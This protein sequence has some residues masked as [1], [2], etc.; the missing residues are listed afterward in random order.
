LIEEKET[1]MSTADKIAEQLTQAQ[2]TIKETQA[3]VEKL[4]KE[5]EESKKPKKWEPKGGSWYITGMGMVKKGPTYKDT[6]ACGLEFETQDA[7]LNAYKEYKT[8]HRLYKL[9]EEL[10]EGWE[11]DWKSTAP[12]FYIYRDSDGHL[13]VDYV[14]EVRLLAGILFKSR[15]VANNAVDIINNGGLE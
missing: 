2:T 7:A 11:P 8:Y 10:N 14:I 12:K 1:Q 3:L 15:E 5:L 9:A 13:V 4:Q 6:A